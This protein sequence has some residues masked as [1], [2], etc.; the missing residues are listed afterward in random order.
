MELYIIIY[1]FRFQ[2]LDPGTDST[3]AVIDAWKTIL[4]RSQVSNRYIQ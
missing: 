1:Y 4:K 3:A 2:W